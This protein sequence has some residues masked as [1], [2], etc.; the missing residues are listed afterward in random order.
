MTL[1]TNPTSVYFKNIE[2]PEIYPVSFQFCLYSSGLRLVRNCA[3]SLHA[4]NV[5]AQDHNVRIG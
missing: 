1:V 2:P 4:V 5:T 3:H